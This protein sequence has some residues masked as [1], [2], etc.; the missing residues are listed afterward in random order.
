MRNLRQR[1]GA[2]V[3]AGVLAAVIGSAVPVFADMGGTKRNTCAFILGQL[4]KVPSD[5]GAATMFRALFLSY[6][7]D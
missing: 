6:D 3:F 7:C 1:F 4:F 5:S 2:F